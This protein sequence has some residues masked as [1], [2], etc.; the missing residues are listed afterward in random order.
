MASA[1]ARNGPALT[2]EMR[3]WARIYV[4]GFNAAD[5]R[6]VSARWLADGQRESEK[7]GGDKLFRVYAGYDRI[8]QF[9]KSGL[10]G[11]VQVELSTTVKRDSRGGLGQR[12]AGRPGIG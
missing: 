9:M 6:E 7:F 2:A 10:G 4:E 8:V 3:R 5:A 1:V 11:E 12:M